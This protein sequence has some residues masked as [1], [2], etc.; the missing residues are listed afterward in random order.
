MQYEGYGFVFARAARY[1]SRIYNKHLSKVSL[2]VSQYNILVSVATFGPINLHDLAERLVVERTALLRTTKPLIK[3]GFVQSAVDPT[4]KK[5]LLYQISVEGLRC[6]ELAATSVLS[7]ETEIEAMF[8]R[9][10]ILSI[11]NHLLLIA[12]ATREEWDSIV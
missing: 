1:I 7:A 12:N 8:P 5:R 4:Y 6:V 9:S 11:R 3:A 10:T 2:T